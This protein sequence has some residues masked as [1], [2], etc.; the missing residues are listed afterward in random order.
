[1]S[2]IGKKS[3]SPTVDDIEKVHAKTEAR[4]AEKQAALEAAVQSVL[5]KH[6]VDLETL[7]RTITI[8]QAQSVDAAS[9]KG[10]S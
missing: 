4:T 1:M 3:E 10:D 8:M 6:N 7:G 2:N 5:T 9:L